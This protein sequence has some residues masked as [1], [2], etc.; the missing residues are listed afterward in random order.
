MHRAD[1]EAL[2]FQVLRSIRSIVRHV[3]R[4]SRQVGR[5]TGLGVPQLLCMRAIEDAPP[6]VEVT[7]AYIADAVHLSRSTVS[8][9]VE[10]LVRAELVTRVRSERDR[11]RVQLG[12]TPDGLERLRSM[13]VPLEADFLRRLVALEPS[14]RAV[15]LESLKKVV[16]LMGADEADASPLLV[17]GAR[18]DT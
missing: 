8:T 5:D 9:L 1:S 18:I 6:E 4:Y 10:K 15:I 12:L 16:D 2:G 11:R 14:E 13:P 7:A 3:S 17:E